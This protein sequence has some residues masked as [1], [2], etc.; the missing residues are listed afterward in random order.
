MEVTVAMSYV[1][2][3]GTGRKALPDLTHAG[4][5]KRQSHR[6]EQNGGHQCWR[7]LGQRRDEGR[8]VSSY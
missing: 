2:K 1:K 5:Y 6:S 4:M 7:E 8:L 3:T